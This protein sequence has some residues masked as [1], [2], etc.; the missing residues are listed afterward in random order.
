[1]FRFDFRLSTFTFEVSLPKVVEG[2]TVDDVI[3]LD[4]A[5]WVMQEKSKIELQSGLTKALKQQ[6]IIALTAAL[7]AIDYALEDGSLFIINP[8]FQ[9]EISH[10][11]AALTKLQE[12]ETAKLKI[13]KLDQPL[14]AEL[15]SYNIPLE[16]VD[17]VM[18]ATFIL[19]GEKPA[20]LA[21]CSMFF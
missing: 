15:K 17:S 3:L 7:D 19:L 16:V 11:Q 5:K 2:R 10:A 12:A 6:D 13:L 1:M 18:K 9:T 21:V 20:S 14:I 8:E 4:N